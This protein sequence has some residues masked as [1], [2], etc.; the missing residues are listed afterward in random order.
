MAAAMLMFKYA[1]LASSSSK[2]AQYSVRAIW[3]L[4]W[5]SV[6]SN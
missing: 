6:G 1:P 4:P 3:L 2:T 5:L